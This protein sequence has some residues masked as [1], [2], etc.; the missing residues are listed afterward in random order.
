MAGVPEAGERRPEAL[1]GP[2]CRQILQG[3]QEGWNRV[4]VVAADS[5]TK[6]AAGTVKIDGGEGGSRTQDPKGGGRIKRP[7]KHRCR[8]SGGRMSA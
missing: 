4:P 7:A 5:E 8:M 2:R 3:R 1:M 6:A